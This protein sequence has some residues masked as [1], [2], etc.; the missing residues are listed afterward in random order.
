[1]AEEEINSDIFI[2]RECYLKMQ[3][4][5]GVQK[6]MK[7]LCLFQMFLYFFRHTGLANGFGQLCKRIHAPLLG[8][9]VFFSVWI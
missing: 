3:H 6:T 9:Q 7:D 1:M 2:G 8:C 4:A 5:Y